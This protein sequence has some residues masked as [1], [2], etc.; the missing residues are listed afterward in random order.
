MEAI[1]ADWHCGKAATAHPARQSSQPPVKSV[2]MRKCSDQTRITVPGRTPEKSVW[3]LLGARSCLAVA[4]RAILAASAAAST[5]SAHSGHSGLHRNSAVAARFADIRGKSTS[6]LASDTG[7]PPARLGFRGIKS[8]LRHA[9]LATQIGAFPT[10][11]MLDKD[12]DDLFL[13]LSRSLLVSP[14]D[15]PESPLSGGDSGPRRDPEKVP[16]KKQ[17]QAARNAISC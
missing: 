8:A 13:V 6:R 1:G 10:G 16:V 4:R 11:L 7:S 9:I 3:V 5:C 2:H 17:R 14:F 15:G 12:G